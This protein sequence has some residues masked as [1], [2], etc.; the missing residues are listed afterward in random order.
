MLPPAV[1]EAALGVALVLLA[2]SFGRDVWW[3]WSHRRDEAP[4]I[5]SRRGPGARGWPA[6][7]APGADGHDARRSSPCV[8]TI[9]VDS[10]RVGRARRS[11]TSRNIFKSSAFLRVP[12]E[13]LVLIALALVLPVTGRR[14]LAVLAGLALT[15]VVVLKV[16]NYE[17]FSLFDRPFEPLGDIGQLGNALETLRCWIGRHSQARLI[18]IG[19]VVGVVAAVVLL[20]LAMLRVTRVAADN[21]RWALRAVAGARR[22]LGGLLRCSAR[23]SSPTRRSPPPSPPACSSTR[24]SSCGP[25]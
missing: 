18:E 1:A 11:R 7:G 8:L 13:G 16:V 12:L 2:E 4:A 20:T 5:P 17:V 21:R 14:I 6:R 3:L 25:K 15:L 22:R 19:A 23:S 24:C 9:L 10:D